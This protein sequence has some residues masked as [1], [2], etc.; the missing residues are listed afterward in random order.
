METQ[1]AFANGEANREKPYM[2]FDWVKAATL[3]V[4]KDWKN[5]IAGLDGD[6]EWTADEI[7]KD[8]KPVLEGYSYLRSTW[9]KPILVNYD[10]GEELEC[11]CMEDNNPRNYDAKSRWDDESLEIIKKGKPKLKKAVPVDDK[12]M[13]ELTV[14]EEKPMLGMTLDEEQE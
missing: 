9:G 13:K 10:T 11:F 7:L 3:I 6:F 4:E 12:T 8:G 2:I 5:V 1:K 14:V